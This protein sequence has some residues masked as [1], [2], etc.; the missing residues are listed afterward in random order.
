MWERQLGSPAQVRPAE[1]V[2]GPQARGAGA[3]AGDR[4]AR[5]Y[6]PSPLL[7]LAEK[8]GSG[9]KPVLSAVEVSPRR[10]TVMVPLKKPRSPKRGPN[11]PLE[12]QGAHH[13]GKLEPGVCRSH[14]LCSEGQATPPV[15]AA[16]PP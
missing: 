13:L 3:R 15:P 5:A 2:Q 11:R 1:Q 12:M 8:L 9:E 6:L 16:P 7:L 14:A 10:A 4:K